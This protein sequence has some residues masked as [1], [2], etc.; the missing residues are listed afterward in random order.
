MSADRRKPVLV[1][2]LG[3]FGGAVASSLMR[4]GHEVLGVDA[5]PLLV[6]AMADQLTQTVQADTTDIDALKAIG[7]GDFSSAVVGI[8]TDIEA[9]VLT[10]LGLSDLEVPSI[11]AKATND[12]HGRILQRTGAH[13]IVYPEARMGERVA[14]LLNG[15]LL[16]FIQLADRF[17]IGK[18]QAPAPIVGATLQMTDVRQKYGITVIGIKRAEEDFVYAVPDTWILPEDIMIIAGSVENIERFAALR[19]PA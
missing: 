1:I 17:A 11:W 2:G 14:H 8:G 7:A 6:Q 18:L 9:S 5:D 12:N 19:G 15:R 13:H 4:M 16:D 3:R 10:V